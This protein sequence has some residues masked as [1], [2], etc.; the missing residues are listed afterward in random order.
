MASRFGRVSVVILAC[1]VGASATACGGR[2]SAASST[3]K[4][5]DDAVMYTKYEGGDITDVPQFDRTVTA[6]DALD[7]EAPPEV[8]ADV[9]VI[10]QQARQ[11]ETLL[12]KAGND[13]ETQFGALFAALLVADTTAAQT[14]SEHIDAYGLRVCRIDLRF[15]TRGIARRKSTTTS[16][17]SKLSVADFEDELR[18][19]P[20]LAGL[21]YKSSVT[22]SG[23]TTVVKVTGGDFDTIDAVNACNDVAHSVYTK[24]PHAVVQI[25][26]RGGT[27]LLTTQRPDDCRVT[28]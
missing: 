20:H 2:A 15:A 8:K 26:G 9:H 10:A 12:A 3:R 19:D 6:I 13:P 27:V 18:S 25:V 23:G 24:A 21:S 14:A 28:T 7:R 5:C 11:A 17:A 22:T 1:A 16:P 4:F